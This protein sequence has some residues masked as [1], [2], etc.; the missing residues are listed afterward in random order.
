MYNGERYLAEAIDGILS[1]TFED[2]ELVVSDNGSSDGT[3]EIVREAM[4]RDPRVRFSRVPENRGAMWNFNEVFRRSRGVFF[5]PAAHDDLHEPTFVERCVDVFHEAPSSVVLVYPRT[6]LIDGEGA[7][8]RE[9]DA[10]LDLREREPAERLRHYLANVGMVNPL[11]G[12]HRR[13]VFG[14][15]RLFQSYVSSDIVLLAEL[16]MRGEF[17]EVPETLFL[18]RDHEGRSERAHGSFSELAAWYDPSHQQR[19]GGR[20][21]RQFRGLLRAVGEAPISRGDRRRCLQVV[22]SDWGFRWKRAMVTELVRSG[23]GLVRP[24]R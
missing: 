8:I 23:V 24:G 11:F 10:G 7:P 18:R 19:L 1:Q 16:A 3:E 4:R 22:M 14:S 17:W 15:T 9:H 2:L 13:R 6:L 5:K 20:R 21:I 12:L